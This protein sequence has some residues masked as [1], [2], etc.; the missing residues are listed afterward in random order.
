MDLTPLT[1][2]KQNQYQF[3]YGNAR[4][5]LSKRTSQVPG[6]NERQFIIW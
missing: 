4:E 5:A 2:K 3:T 6:D 1:N